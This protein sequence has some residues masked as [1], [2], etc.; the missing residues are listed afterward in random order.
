MIDLKKFVVA[1]VVAVFAGALLFGLSRGFLN[2]YHLVRAG[3][4]YYA[5]VHG[6]VNATQPMLVCRYL[7]LTGTRTSVLIWSEARPDCPFWLDE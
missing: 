3:E 1:V 4:T 6:E 5:P 2:G 7:S